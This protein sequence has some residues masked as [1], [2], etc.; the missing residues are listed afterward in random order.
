MS[1]GTWTQDLKYAWRTLRK[2]PGFAAAAIATLALG[3]GA[4]TAI[5]SVVNAVLLKPL[6][7]TDPD[8]LRAV[9]I[10]IPQFRD[11][12]PSMPVR[13]R[14]FLE[15]R[16]SGVAFSEL[17]LFRST[18]LNLT[19]A[20]EP[21][22]LGA[23][24]VS[25]NLLSTLGVQPERGRGFLPDE[26]QPGRGSEVILSHDFWM[27]R[28][29]GDPAMVNRQIEMDGRQY[30]VVGILPADF[31]FPTGK[32]FHP[33]LPLAEHIDVWVP[34]EL[35]DSEIRNTGNLDYGVIGRLKPGLDPR[36]AAQELDATSVR[37]SRQD[38]PT[39][40]LD[41]HT[42]MVPLREVF[43]G[44]VRQGLILLLAAVGLLLLIACVNLANLVMARMTGRSREFAT[45]AALGAGR[46][47]LIRQLLTESV[48]LASLG[49][50]AGVALANWGVRLAVALGPRDL[51]MLQRAGDSTLGGPVL[52]FTSAIALLTGMLFGLIPAI[53]TFRGEL[54]EDLKEGSRGFTDGIR[55][56]RLRRVLVTV[57]VALSTALLAAAG[58]LLHSFV[59]VVNSDKGF[60]VERILAVDLS[61]PQ[62]NYTGAQQRTGFFREV[63]RRLESLPGVTAVGAVTDLPLTNEN[64]NKL[65][66]L[67][68][69]TTVRLDRPVAAWRHATPGYFE[70]IGIPL[71]AGRLFREQEPMPVAVL[72]QSMAKALWPDQ[73]PGGAI[74]RG[75]REG[76]PRGPLIR[77]V[78]VVADVRTTALDR[79]P[80]PQMYRPYTQGSDA[81]MSVVMRST[82]DPIS[83]GSAIRA[84][85]REVDGSLPVPAMR[86]MGEMVSAS[87]AQR[88]FQMVLIVM[89]AAL[90]LVLAVVGIYGVVN[91]SV[92][93]R[94]RE[95]GLRMALGAQQSDVLRSVV[96][97][98]LSPVVVGIALGAV[99]A[100]LAARALRSLLFGVEPLDPVALG[101]VSCVLLLA[102]TAACYLPARWASQ[103]DPLLA[104][105]HE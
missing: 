2:S 14:D 11:K 50:A 7:Y 102:A 37:F 17:S 47:R 22:R 56:G 18:G 10:E 19:G 45:R 80:M 12:T 95:I 44:N 29:G 4:N 97:E 67:E 98:G 30:L 96:W 16:R 65:V 24:R 78:G 48:L 13:P 103:L 9:Y 43:T 60:A 49:G 6:P 21:E 83:L 87:L 88:R 35:S 84:A 28:Y 73:G 59:N 79:R 51:M 52:W 104:L 15:W 92:L 89:F 3:I 101:G 55:A 71:V 46:A 1:L 25:A 72:S 86:T 82:R 32:Q 105:R 77:I 90:A 74:G 69:D 40:R 100:T 31:V 8:R 99:G 41:F 27:R 39:L 57:E 26:D 33:L 54:H 94:T 64:Q 36:Q 53:E 42:Q 85:I 5:F 68:S 66:I 63:T 61:L 38:M 34:I 58:L 20:G 81:D 93:R 62:K 91:Y 76:S 70:A 75:V 23:L